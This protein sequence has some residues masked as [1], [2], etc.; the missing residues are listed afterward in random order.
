M[1][2]GYSLY[3]E[4][5]T[6]RTTKVLRQIGCSARHFIRNFASPAPSPDHY[7]ILA[8]MLVLTYSRLTIETRRDIWALWHALAIPRWNPPIWPLGTVLAVSVPNG[9]TKGPLLFELLFTSFQSSEHWA[10]TTPKRILCIFTFS[11]KY[12][13]YLLGTEGIVWDF[14]YF[15]ESSWGHGFP[16]FS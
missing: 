15:R 8:R 4:E 16:R 3:I 13:L 7:R 9:L 5:H 10:I 2:R 11:E 1:Q 14:I 6:L 12:W